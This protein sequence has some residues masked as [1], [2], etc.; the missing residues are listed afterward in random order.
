MLVRGKPP[1][2]KLVQQGGGE[3]GQGGKAGSGTGRGKAQRGRYKVRAPVPVVLV[4][5]EGQVTEG[6]H[7]IHGVPDALR[8]PDGGRALAAPRQ[9]HGAD[10]S[11]QEASQA[12]HQAKPNQ[13]K[14]STQEAS[15]AAGDSSGPLGPEAERQVEGADTLPFKDTLSSKDSL[16]S[17]DTHPSKDS[18]PSKDTL[19]SQD[20][21]PPSKNPVEGV[22]TRSA[23][24]GLEHPPDAAPLVGR[25]TRARK[26]PRGKAPATTAADSSTAAATNKGPAPAPAPTTTTASA[27]ATTTA[28]STTTTTAP[29]STTDQATAPASATTTY[30]ATATARVTTTA[31]GPEFPEQ[32]SDTVYHRVRLS[33]MPRYIPQLSAPRHS[34]DDA[35]AE[36]SE[37]DEV[38][39]VEDTGCPE[40]A[41][42]VSASA[43]GAASRAAVRA[44]KAEANRQEC[45]KEEARAALSQVGG[46]VASA[47]QRTTNSNRPVWL[48]TSHGM[49][50]FISPS[51]PPRASSAVPA[52]RPPPAKWGNVP[53]KG[54]R[55]NKGGS[56][57]GSADELR[58]DLA[59]LLPN[60]T[61]S[62]PRNLEQLMNGTGEAGTTG[63]EGITALAVGIRGR[64]DKACEEGITALAVGIRGRPDKAWEKVQK[65]GSPIVEIALLLTECIQHGLR[66]IAFCRSRRLCELV[67]CYT[68]E[69][70]K[71]S[72]PDLINSF[73]V[74]RGGYSPEERRQ[75]ESELFRGDLL[76]A[77]ATNAL[78]LGVDVGA[79]DVTL[80]LGFPGSIASLRQQAGRAGRR[81]QPSLSLYVAFD[82]PLD[83]YFMS[84]PKEL[85]ALSTESAKELFALSTEA[86]KELFTLPTEAAKEQL[87]LFTEAAKELFA[88]STESAKV[89]VSNLA[90]VRQ[91]II[92]AAA[93][94]PLNMAPDS[95]DSRLFQH[96]L[97]Q[98]ATE[99]LL[100]TEQLGL[101]PRLRATF[102]AAPT[103][104]PQTSQ[105]PGGGSGAGGDV[106]AHAYLTHGGSDWANSDNTPRDRAHSDSPQS[107]RTHSD[108]T[109]S[110]RTRFLHY[111]GST[112][113][114][115]SSFGLRCIDSESIAVVEEGTNKVYEHIEMCIAFYHV[116]G[117]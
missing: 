94:L 82:G 110:D 60:L 74:Y 88:L 12:V 20:I 102:Q 29:A 50:P 71:A 37:S 2:G 76:A 106:S 64:S 77:V 61:S 35:R 3:A 31:L 23:A 18:L 34:N 33:E 45:V 42:P 65:R 8:L 47:K 66:S 67:A 41:P 57:G 44:A 62:L 32:A 5:K 75:I 80:H 55:H 30:Q 86:A 91:H 9:Q 68:R 43:L 51:K 27:P 83:Q 114:V 115:A 26:P 92:A 104:P 59:K 81:E 113:N 93:E 63:E 38:T 87:T 54:R 85:F 56:Q 105:H 22:R 4:G 6:V 84:H 109:H 25:T 14:P 107:D 19:P 52:T 97:L 28:P 96:G 11:M 116:Y 39:I 16:S 90:V 72:A 53:G 117:E 21:L 1:G 103:P 40:E 95:L 112:E 73:K 108:R 78:E 15:P 46:T 99:Q 69:L 98:E 100:A 7:K 70:L 10:A 13:A 48:Y 24:R 79:L 17:K 111:T 89:D 101:H 36:N 58:P 49:R